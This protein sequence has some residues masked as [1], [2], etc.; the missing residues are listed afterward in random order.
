M[1]TDT[2]HSQLCELKQ[3]LDKKMLKMVQCP[4]VR[5]LA[6]GHQGIIVFRRAWSP[7]SLN[8]MFLFKS[9]DLFMLSKQP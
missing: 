7:A 5:L 2:I 8:R 4:V 1:R 3:P 9:A 6:Y